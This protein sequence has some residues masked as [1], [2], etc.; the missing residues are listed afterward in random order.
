MT[1][2]ER[3]FA[4]KLLAYGLAGNGK[5]EQAGKLAGE[6]MTR[7][8]W[9]SQHRALLGLREAV[10]KRIHELAAEAREEN[11]SYSLHMADAATDTI[12]RDVFLGLVSFEQEMLYEIDA[13]LRRIEDGSY[14]ICEL[15]GRPIP[16]ARLEAIPWARFALDAQKKI[17][18]EF[19]PHIGALGR[20]RFE[21]QEQPEAA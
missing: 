19:H 21:K 2:T 15:T 18:G 10:L 6:R 16:A 13:A 7:R 5:A 11:P 17:E 20:I 4:M 12:D 3:D 8:R 14:G 9:L 1:K